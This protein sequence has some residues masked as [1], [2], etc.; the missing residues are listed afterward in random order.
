MLT[1]GWIAATFGD[2]TKLSTEIDLG[3]HYNRVLIIMP[4]VLDGAN[5]YATVTVCNVSGGTFRA[6]HNIYLTVPADVTAVVAKA[7]VIVIAG[8]RYLKLATTTNQAT[9]STAYI[10]GVPW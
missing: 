1:S 9:T 10:I 3:N 4:A 7:S 8:A 2:G 5:A 6:L